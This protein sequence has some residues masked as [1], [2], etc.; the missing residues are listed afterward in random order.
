M[1]YLWNNAIN[2]K[3]E[4]K[5]HKYKS[6]NGWM[7]WAN[8]NKQTDTGKN[9]RYKHVKRKL[10]GIIKKIIQLWKYGKFK[11][12]R[13]NLVSK[14]TP[15]NKKKLFVLFVEVICLREKNNVLW[16]FVRVLKTTLHWH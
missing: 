6:N 11:L 7:W 10:W 3:T 4:K 14:L 12:N 1:V 2:V 5:K 15:E 8:N 13:K 16:K 9:W